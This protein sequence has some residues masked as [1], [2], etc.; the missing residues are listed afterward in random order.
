MERRTSPCMRSLNTLY[1]VSGTCAFNAIFH[2]F[3]YYLP[4]R[5]RIMVTPLSAYAER[6]RGLIIELQLVFRDLILGRA[7]PPNMFIRELNKFSNPDFP[8]LFYPSE[9][10]GTARGTVE[11]LRFALV[12]ANRMLSIYMGVTWLV[13][14][15]TLP[16]QMSGQLKLISEYDIILD[17]TPFG[18]AYDLLLRCMRYNG[19]LHFHYGH[20]FKVSSETP[21]PWRSDLL[22]G[23][24]FEPA[25]VLRADGVQPYSLYGIVYL[26]DVLS[27][28]GFD[29]GFVALYGYFA[30]DSLH[31]HI[32]DNGGTQSMRH[33]M[34]I[35]SVMPSQYKN[36]HIYDLFYIPTSSLKRATAYDKEAEV[37]FTRAF[38][39]DFFFKPVY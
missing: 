11:Q 33:E 29:H 32:F 8:K 14:T 31:W 10:G 27:E 37:D 19:M 34:D 18:T 6:Y 17:N 36:V 16:A 22:F 5:D 2:L 13:Q 23:H 35:Y 15:R 24:D 3:F 30:G 1:N 38:D 21:F 7:T 9:C 4:F 26:A 20:P 12:A 25:R 39:A 28:T